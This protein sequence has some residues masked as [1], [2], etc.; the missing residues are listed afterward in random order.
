MNKMIA[1]GVV[2]VLCHVGTASAG[3]PGWCK[4]AEDARYDLRDL[5]STEVGEVIS[6]L[7]LAT[8]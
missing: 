6:T 4:D 2:A 3:V 7:A 5:S 8:C 1:A